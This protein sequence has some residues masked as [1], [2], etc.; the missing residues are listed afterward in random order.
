MRAF[1]INAS[2]RIQVEDIDRPK[3]AADEVLLRVGAAGICHSDV[4]LIGIA[5]YLGGQLPFTA[6]HEIAGWI[7]ELGSGVTGL[8]EG[9]AV[10]VYG[11]IGCGY[12]GECLTGRD[13][14][15]NGGIGAIGV[16]RDGGLAEYVTVPA[17][18][19]LA[20]DELD[21][22]QAATLTD[23]GVTAYSPVRRAREWLGPGSVA[24]VIGIGGLGHLAVQ[25]VAALTPARIIAVDVATASLDLAKCVGAHH[26]VAADESAAAD[27][28]RL[29]GP[30]AIDVAFDFVGADPTL[31]LAANLVKPGGAIYLTGL[32]NGSLAVSAGLDSVIAPEV[33]IT[34]TL[35]G[36]R[37]DLHD[38]IALARAGQLRAHASTHSL[39]EVPSLLAA[40]ERGGEILGR[41]VVTFPA[42]ERDRG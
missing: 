24:L 20:I 28:E 27:I 2:D 3:P 34:R 12:C 23:A 29:C 4:Q 9:V 26:V 17:R 10:A 41:A 35:S 38:V 15:C 14:L 11:L 36:S 30:R 16:T 22:V 19:V 33:Q 8:Q 31:G 1:R 25:I 42:P 7:E 18:N 21:V 6:G 5:G 37:R 39:D 13:P 32:G 40:L